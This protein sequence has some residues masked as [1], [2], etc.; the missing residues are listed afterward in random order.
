MNAPTN[1]GYGL[2]NIVDLQGVATRQSDGAQF[3]FGAAVNINQSNRGIPVTDPAQPGLNPICKQRIIEAGGLHLPLSAGGAM[4]VT[5]DPRGWFKLPID[6]SSLPLVTSDV[7]EL[8]QTTSYGSAQY[9]IPDT[10]FASGLGATQGANLF[11]GI[12]TGGPGA[13]SLTFTESP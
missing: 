13:Y 5:I 10:S 7:C 12:L 4:Q 8:D 11:T 1:T 9:C 2:P 6:F 3:T